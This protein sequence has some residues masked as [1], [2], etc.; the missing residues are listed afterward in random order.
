MLDLCRSD[1][2]QG[3][4]MPRSRS[5]GLVI[6]LSLLATDSVALFTAWGCSTPCEELAARICACEQTRSAQD[7][8]ERRASQQQD[9]AAPSAGTQER[10]ESLLDSCDCFALDTAA[11]KRSCGLAE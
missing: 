6:R 2:L 4:V 8:C 1:A 9:A 3:S 5:G 10:C 11:G 7:A